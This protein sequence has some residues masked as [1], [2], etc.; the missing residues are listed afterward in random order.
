MS[1]FTGAEQTDGLWCGWDRC[2]DAEAAHQP[3]ILDS[4]VLLVDKTKE[5]IRVSLLLGGVA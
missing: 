5:V 3:Y 1:S 2:E 4:T